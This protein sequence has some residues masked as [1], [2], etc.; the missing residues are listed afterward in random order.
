MALI[1]WHTVCTSGDTMAAVKTLAAIETLEPNSIG[2]IWTPDAC[3]AGAT[4]AGLR[5]LSQGGVIELRPESGLGRLSRDD[6][7]LCPTAW[8][9]TPLSWIRLL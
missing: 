3:R 1:H 2:L 6:A 8:D 7:S 9:G 4:V 5:A